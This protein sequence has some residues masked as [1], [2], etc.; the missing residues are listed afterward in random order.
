MC[1]KCSAEE[2]A[3]M[4]QLDA[5]GGDAPEVWANFTTRTE[6]LDLERFYNGRRLVM[7]ALQRRWPLARYASRLEYTGGYTVNS[8]GRRFP[9]WHTLLKGIAAAD[10]PAAK[11]I[12]VAVWCRH[13]DALP[14]GQYMEPIDSAQGVIGYIT[15]HFK[16]SNQTPPDGFTG[17]RFFTS[18]DYFTGATVKVARARARESIARRRLTNR[19]IAAGLG[20]HDVELVVA[21]GLV[22]AA[23]TVWVV[24]NER[25]VR[26]GD[27]AH[28]VVRQL[29]GPARLRPVGE[30]AAADRRGRLA[31]AAVRGDVATAMPA[32]MVAVELDGQYCDVPSGPRHRPI[33]ERRAV[34]DRWQLVNGEL[35]PRS[36]RTKPAPVS[37]P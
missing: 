9:H 3:E 28:D 37:A 25:G 30:D 14:A 15:Q 17:R 11:A 32:P 21:E 29:L 8:R 2:D 4:L 23:A 31:L 12:A 10:A 34:A 19:A 35:V 6:T 7:R 24:V 36:V 16:K 22:R 20:A 5:A 1:A 26:V 27:Q 33:D 18:R 13:V